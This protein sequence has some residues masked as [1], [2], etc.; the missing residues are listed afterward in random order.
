[1]RIEISALFISCVHL[2]GC[3]TDPADAAAPDTGAIPD[4]ATMEQAALNA[5]WGS[6]VTVRVEGDDLVIESDGLPNHGTLSA[7]ATFGGGDV[8]V[9]A[10]NPTTLTIPLV[11]SASDVETQ[12]SL[13]AIGI[14][15]SGAV[16]FN[17]YEG[18]GTTVALDD[19]FTDASGNP[20]L[21]DCNGHPI[22]MSGQYHYHGIPRC[23]SDELDAAGEHSRLVGYLLDGFPIYGPQG[24]SGVVPDDLDTCLGHFGPTP[25]FPDGVYH[26]HTTATSPYISACYAGVVDAVMGGGPGGGPMP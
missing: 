6:N 18:D 23:I 8:A 20:F 19:N 24:E 16:F 13:G 21:D 25:E 12:S 11:P 1:M 7:Y 17:P 3:S 22:P 15:V 2:A 9:A 10:A 14:A 26:Y 4:A 5:T